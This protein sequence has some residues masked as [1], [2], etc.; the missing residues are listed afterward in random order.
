[1]NSEL[2]HKVSDILLEVSE[3]VILPSF[4]EGV[5]TASWEKTPGEYVTRVDQLAEG[6]I[7]A[8]L[9][10]LLPGSVVVGE[11]A[12]AARPQLLSHLHDEVAWL[13]DPLDGTRNFASGHEP[14]AM[15]LALLRQG[16]AVAAWILDPLTNRLIV[17]EDGAGAWRGEDR[18][19]C[20]QQ[21]PT[22]RTADAIVSDAFVQPAEQGWLAGFK[23]ALGNVR[24]TRRCAGAEYP[25][26][27]LG[28]LDLILYWRTL[29]WDHAAGA[30][31][32]TEAGGVVRQL[33][34]SA[35]DPARSKP[36]LVSA[37]NEDLMKQLLSSR[38]CQSDG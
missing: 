38:P 17:A 10:E 21:S 36:G 29:P 24:P 28:D 33:D 37:A 31:V 7:S 1:M 6:R 35:Y 14:F 8:R 18:L 25:L 32:V 11:E 13:L 5:A 2:I 12:C 27:A 15:M 16:R 4:Q 23:A 34:G 26:L 22:L 30:L 3:G 19:R 20:R 9:G